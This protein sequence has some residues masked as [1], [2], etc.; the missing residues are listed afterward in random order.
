L[1]GQ[2]QRE[3]PFPQEGKFTFHHLQAQATLYKH[4]ALKADFS[5]ES[6]LPKLKRGKRERDIFRS[7]KPF[8]PLKEQRK[9]KT[10]EI[11]KPGEC[12]FF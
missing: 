9:I 1:C 5:S 7:K 8:P 10:Q 6:D 11:P 12:E 3:A 4:F 2:T